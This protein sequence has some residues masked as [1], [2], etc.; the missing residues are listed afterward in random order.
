VELVAQDYD[1]MV[2]AGYFFE[3]HDPP[4]FTE[5]LGRLAHLEGEINGGLGGS[6]AP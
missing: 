5:I 4:P 1:E 3:G 2:R 6:G